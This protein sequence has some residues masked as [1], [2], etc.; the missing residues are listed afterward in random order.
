MQNF[1]V[2]LSKMTW[3]LDSESIRG[4]KLEPACTCEY[5][6]TF[7]ALVRPQRLAIYTS[8]RIRPPSRRLCA[9]EDSSYV[10]T[11]IIRSRRRI[12]RLGRRVPTITFYLS[13]W[14]NQAVRWHLRLSLFHVPVLLSMPTRACPS[15]D[16]HVLIVTSA[17]TA[18][19][20]CCGML[21]TP[22]QR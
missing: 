3:T 4:D 1:G 21:V 18:E 11:R 16:F 5:S 15:Y 7:G 2:Y 19:V 12:I 6:L 13:A 10:C 22:T 17:L 8:L 9:H 20:L 14:K